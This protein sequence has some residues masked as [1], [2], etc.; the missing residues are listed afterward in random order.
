[1]CG[2]LLARILEA[3]GRMLIDQLDTPFSA[4]KRWAVRDTIHQEYPLCTLGERPEHCVQPALARHVQELQLD[5][6][7]PLPVGHHLVVDP[8]T[9][10]ILS[11]G[12]VIP[13]TLQDLAQ[14]HVAVVYQ[15]EFEQ[16]VVALD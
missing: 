15:Q 1:M 10:D 11:L 12:R 9:V 16:V 13:H 4:V 5:P 2:K 3:L 14:A 7:A 6:L 8:I